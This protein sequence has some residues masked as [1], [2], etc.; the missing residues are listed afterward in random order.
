MVFDVNTDDDDEQ[1][2]KIKLERTIISHDKI[3]NMCNQ[4]RA[5]ESIFACSRDPIIKLMYIG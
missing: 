2:Y 5:T 1:T 4:L 3:V